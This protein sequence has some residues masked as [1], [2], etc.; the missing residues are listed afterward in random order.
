MN[1]KKATTKEINTHKTFS[2]HNLLLLFTNASERLSEQTN[3]R[4]IVCVCVHV[5]V[6]VCLGYALVPDS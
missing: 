6:F 1:K 5:C 2:I 4:V 3:E